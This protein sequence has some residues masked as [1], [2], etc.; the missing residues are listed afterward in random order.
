[1]YKLQNGKLI[2]PPKVWKGIVGYD[3]DL[4]RLIKDGWKPLIETGSGELFEYV[5]R[6]DHIEKRFYEKPYDYREERR[7]AYPDLGD[8]VD[9]ILKA[10]DGYPEELEV[11]MAQRNLIKQNIKKTEND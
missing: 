10:Y 11:I 6:K 4:E 3:K 5:E 2:T 1:M 7:K 9:A 8:V